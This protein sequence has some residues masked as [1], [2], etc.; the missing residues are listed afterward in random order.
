MR[1]VAALVVVALA[2]AAWA[3]KPARTQ[4]AGGEH[5]RIETDRGP[6][7]VWVPPGYRSE[8]AGIALYVHGYYT[9][10]DRAWKQHRL[11]EQFRAS[12]RNALFIA[13]E[14]PGGLA[15]KVFWPD[16]GDLLHEV[17]RQTGL[18]RPWGAVVAMVHS[19]G[20][21]TAAAW[22]DDDLLDD[23]VLLDAMYGEEEAFGDWTR[24]PGHNLVLVGADTLRWTEPFA[25]DLRMP[26]LD[27]IPAD[28]PAPGTY[29]LRSGL[30]HM[31]LVTSG[32]V[33]PILYRTTRLP[34]AA[35]AR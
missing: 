1:W 29:Y 24:A 3:G 12:G 28:P 20:Y 32:K 5:I 14:A 25:R 35:A 16:L 9:N 8:T 34:A 33:I 10:V 26:S 30:R 15:Q 6:V 13:P 27:A 23:L 11:A 19:G 22:L 18:R 4:E 31:D 7:H 21:R 2:S 17:R